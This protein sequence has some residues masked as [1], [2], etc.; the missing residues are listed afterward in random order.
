MYVFVCVCVCVCVCVNHVL[1]LQD[2]SKRLGPSSCPAH[3]AWGVHYRLCSV[4]S[5]A[6]HT[7]A[8]RA[9]AGVRVLDGVQLLLRV[10][11]WR[12]SRVHTG[13]IAGSLLIDTH[14]HKHTHTHT[15][16]HTKT[17]TNRHTH[18]H[19]NAR[20]GLVSGLRLAMFEV[21]QL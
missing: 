10:Q 13:A 3:H 12:V 9:W 19:T 20:T 11:L 15:H 6:H 2:D 4:S 14:T 21:W 17:H 18:T 1:R 5:A 7:G 8:P 16:T